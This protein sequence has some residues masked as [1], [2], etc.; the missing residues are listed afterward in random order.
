MQKEI[1]QGSE[2]FTCFGDA[3]ALYK[4]VGTV[5]DTEAY[6]K[7]VDARVKVY[8]DKHNNP[9]GRE[10]ALGIMSVLVGEKDDQRYYRLLSIIEYH[11]LTDKAVARDLVH[12]AA[13]VAT[14]WK[15]DE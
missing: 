3:F 8:M 1:K 15:G 5:E 4:S 6:W 13:H 11:A 10:L 14:K 12:V 9:L 2:D 7:D